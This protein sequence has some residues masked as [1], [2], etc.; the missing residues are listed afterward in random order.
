VARNYFLDK[1]EDGITAQ[2]I[3]EYLPLSLK[4]D[5]EGIRGRYEIPIV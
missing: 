1:G 4:R 5:R 2:D 3:L